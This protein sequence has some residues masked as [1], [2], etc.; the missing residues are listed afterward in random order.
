MN[1]DQFKKAKS[2]AG[3][4]A[5][6]D[7]SGGS[8]PKALKLYGIA[9]D[10]YSRRRAD[11]RPGARDAHPHHHQPRLRRRPHHGRDP[12]REDDG[13]R[14]RGPPI[15]DYLWNVKHVVPFLKVDKGLAD[16]QDGAQVMKPIPGLDDLLARAGDKGIFGT[17]MRSFI[18]LPGAGVDA[19]VEQQFEVGRQILGGGPRARSSSRRSTSTARSKAE[20]EDQL[21]AAL[22]AGVNALGDDQAVMLKLTLPDT[23]NLYSELVE[24]P[25]VVRVRRAVRR[26]QPRRGV[27][28]A[29]PQQRRHRELLAGADRRSHRAA[30][31]PR[32][33]TRRWM[34]RSPRSP[35]RQVPD[36]LRAS[37]AR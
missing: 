13:P 32:S 11:V 18:K 29:R 1:T 12:V 23:D 8:T 2:G 17:K 24:H 34:R 6:L 22:L 26:L 28:E 16:E 30:E 15:A 20:A 5:A 9:E 35:R 4:I 31:R 7:Q 36:A 19:V 10:A 21:K 33:S 37:C 25:K 27:R 14:D 3:F